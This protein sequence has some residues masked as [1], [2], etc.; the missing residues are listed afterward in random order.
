MR[1][2]LS[3]SDQGFRVDSKVCW[4]QDDTESDDS[5]SDTEEDE[6]NLMFLRSLAGRDNVLS[7]PSSGLVSALKKLEQSFKDYTNAGP[8]AHR[9]LL[10]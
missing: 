4:L 5:D 9:T 10:L 7:V 1:R 6:E 2:K 8:S 3:P